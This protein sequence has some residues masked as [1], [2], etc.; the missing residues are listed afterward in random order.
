MKQREN[1][2]LQY[3]D[4]LNNLVEVSKINPDMTDEILYKTCV[5]FFSDGYETA[6]LVNYISF[7]SDN[8]NSTFQVF[9]VLAYHLTVYPEVQRRLQEEIDEVFDS[10]DEDDEITADDI[11][12]MTYLDQVIRNA[13][14]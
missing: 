1:K 5:Q 14:L 13:Q 3:N 9:G 11:T 4:M 12:N 10:K 8:Y 2:N 6:S 7:N